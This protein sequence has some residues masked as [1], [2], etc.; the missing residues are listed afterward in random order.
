MRHAWLAACVPMAA[1]SALALLALRADA[2][3]TPSRIDDGEALRV[4]QAAIGRTLEGLVFTTVAG[5]RLAIEDL[6]GRPL[7]LSLVYTSCYYVCSGITLQLRKSV[8]IARDALGP[9]SFDVL[10]VGF[11]TPNDTPTR[12]GQY[13]RERGVHVRGWTFASTDAPTMERLTQAV[14]F[15]YR[16]SPK[17]F[18]HITQTTIIDARGRV[19][20]QVYGQEFAPPQLVEPLKRLALGKALEAGGIESVVGRLKLICTIYDPTS[21]RYRFDYSLIVEIVAGLLAL[22]IAATGIAAACRNVR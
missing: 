18:D 3:G 5:D 19:V 8:S 4:S 10:T 16:P 7:V 9:G 13:A 11:D 14:G 2:T 1:F 20:R 22:G 15:T 12:M 17:G 6:R 21:G